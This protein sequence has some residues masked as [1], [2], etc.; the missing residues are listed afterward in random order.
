MTSNPLHEKQCDRNDYCYYYFG[1]IHEG[2]GVKDSRWR[3]LVILGLTQSIFEHYS[4][5]ISHSIRV[6]VYTKR[7]IAI[8]III[9]C[10]CTCTCVYVSKSVCVHVYVCVFVMQMSFGIFTLRPDRR[11]PTIIIYIMTSSRK[12][13]PKNLLLRR[14][15]VTNHI[16]GRTVY[17]YDIFIIQFSTTV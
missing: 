3:R 15:L 1:F 9:T 8:I 17:T 10:I 4:K 14:R 12:S 16:V 11:G 2:R 13:K 6:C 7:A 5:F